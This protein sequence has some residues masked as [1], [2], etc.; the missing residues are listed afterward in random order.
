MTRH[1]IALIGLGLGS[2][3]HVRSLVDLG[4][5]AEVAAAFSRSA[6][7]R[8]AFAASTGLAVTGDLEAIFADAAIDAVA[9]LTPPASHLDLV[10]RAC[11]ARKNILL[12]KP[13]DITMARSQA[14]VTAVAAAGVTAAVMLQHRFKPS[15]R[16]LAAVLAGG[17]LGDII[18]VSA[19]VPLWR[20]QGY[21][22]VE[23]RGTKARDG[24][25]VLVSQAIH[26]ID[27]MRSLV[28]PVCGPVA[29]VSG[30]ARH[31]AGHRM[32]TEDIAS[33][34]LR[35]RNGAIGSIDATT[36]AWPGSP[37]RIEI[38]GT[39]GTASL[40]GTGLTLRWQDGRAEDLPPDALSGGTGADPMAFDPAFHRAV[41][42]DFLDAVDTA[43]APAITPGDALATHY[44]IDAM[45]QSAAEDGMPVDVRR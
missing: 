31:G 16:R 13:L 3:P 43:R 39:A 45:L 40:A 12:E 20:P 29:R 19:R 15:A 26:T 9:I 35:F 28:E 42:S 4:G 27:L 24:G 32:E 14:I 5:R 36:C 7:R 33:A 37:E 1:R 17:G 22:D 30:F 34:A 11:A 21:Y 8:Q 41:W 10:Q 18:G 6:A 25:G 38:I 44:L 23:G 2:G